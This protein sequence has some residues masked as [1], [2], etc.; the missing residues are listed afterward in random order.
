MTTPTV[1]AVIPAY[2]SEKYVAD[3]IRSVLEQSHASVECIVVDDGSTDATAEVVRSFGK[4]VF[5][6]HQAN[7]GVS[8]ARNAGVAAASGEFVAFLDADDAWLPE[9]TMRQLD[10]F[11]KLAAPG[12]VHGAIWFVDEGL[13]RLRVGPIAKDEQALRHAIALE[14]PGIRV[15]QTAMLQRSLFEEIGGFDETLSTSADLDLAIRA[16]TRGVAGVQDPVALYRVHDGQ[17]SQ[18]PLA[19]QRDAI[20][21]LRKAFSNPE[22]PA[23]LRKLRRRA[24]ANLW[25][26]LS[27]MRLRRKEYLAFSLSI[28]RSMFHQP[29]IVAFR[30]FRRLLVRS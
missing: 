23:H 13:N 24:H 12:L 29:G 9:K 20:I 30:L 25:L 17:M 7:K 1:S 16:A 26:M 8:A 19:T 28:L 27:V 11:S 10:L 14:P 18:D 3:A 2:N 6:I 22:V 15:A 21:V 5:Y 4:A